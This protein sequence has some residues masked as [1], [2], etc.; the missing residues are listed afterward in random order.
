MKQINVSLFSPFLPVS[1]ISALQL[2][3]FDVDIKALR[4]YI[5]HY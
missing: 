5:Y 2:R 4:M 3:N 1:K